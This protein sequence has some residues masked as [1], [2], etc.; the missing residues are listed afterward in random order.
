M[1]AHGLN[2]RFLA[3]GMIKLSPDDLPAEFFSWSR[4]EQIEW[5]KERWNNLSREDLLKAVAYL[6][7]EEDSVPDC[8]EVDNENYDILAQTPAWAAFDRPG[9]SVLEPIEP[10]E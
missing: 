4:E 7:I 3:Q 6:D 9:S 8:L 5:A 10:G 2:I 1:N